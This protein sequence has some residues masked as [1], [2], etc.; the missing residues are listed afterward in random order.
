MTKNNKLEFLNKKFSSK[1]IGFLK[2]DSET[3]KTVD[4]IPEEY[5]ADKIYS[6]NL[7]MESFLGRLEQAHIP[8]E[9]FICAVVRQ[10]IPAKN[11][12]STYFETE[13]K[14]ST[15]TAAEDRT[16]K[17]IT[18]KQPE[19]KNKT[20]QHDK[21]TGCSII[22]STEILLA[23]IAK[24]THGLWDRISDNIFVLIMGKNEEN[25]EKTIKDIKTN[26][27]KICN[28]PVSMGIAEFP[29]LNFTRKDVFYNAIKAID[30]SAFLGNDNIVSF[31]AVSLNISGDR[32][33]HMG[34]IEDAAE[35]YKKG[36]EIE[37]NNINLINSL[38]V[39][40][41]M[42]K[43]L[44]M[45]EKEF[46][47]AL[48]IDKNELM[49]VYNTGLIYEIMNKK[50]EALKYFIKASKI[51]DKIF[52]VE[53]RTGQL[54]YIT[55]DLEQALFHLTKAAELNPISGAPLRIMGD[56]FLETNEYEK[57]VI[58]YKKAIKINPEDAPSLSGLSSAFELQNKNLDIALSF[59]RKSVSMEPEN[60]LFRERLDKIYK[61]KDPDNIV[62]LKFEKS[63]T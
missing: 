52:E 24:N 38:G 29:F 45:A 56:I 10:N 22:H 32:L 48:N 30:H 50:K 9:K 2:N 62:K 21:K 8:N 23:G 36:L 39:C 35:E 60:H 26:L 27:N 5:L 33:Y 58:T 28:S 34:R 14:D 59:A 43:K 15:P 47:K 46:K 63:Y 40:F 17:N 57:A 25:N 18:T 42:M 6:N 4:I 3:E 51:N 13:H 54:F 37:N 12:T 7:W 1:E 41:G 16:K 61:K 44:E 20:K 11:K 55:E 31:D 19:P 49:A 53:L